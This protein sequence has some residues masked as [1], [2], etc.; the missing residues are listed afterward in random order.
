MSRSGNPAVRRAEEEA[1]RAAELARSE[2]SWDA[3]PFAGFPEE[4]IDHEAMEHAKADAEPIIGELVAAGGAVA[5]LEDELCRRLGRLLSAQDALRATSGTSDRAL[6]FDQ[7]AYSPELLLDV[8]S[9]NIALEA[10]RA[11][12]GI[13]DPDEQQRRWR[14]LVA[15]ARIVPHPD[16]RI[17]IGAVED[18]R[19]AVVQFPDASMVTTPTGPAMWCRDVY[20]TRFGI[21]APFSAPEGPDR[22]YLWDIDTCNGEAHTVGAGYFPTSTQ[23][24][25][26][27][28]EAVGPNAAAQA[29]LS[30]VSDAGLAD[31]ILPVAGE[32]RLGGESESQYAEFHRSRRLAQEL[33]A[34]ELRSDLPSTEPT[35]PGHEA[36]D[37]SW[38]AEFADWRAKHRPGQKAV[39]AGFPQDGEPFTDD[40]AYRELA[41]I[42]L[43]D[44]LP[45]LAHACSPHRITLAAR[46]IG[47]LYDPDTADVL[48]HLLPDLATWLTE[49][50][51]LPPEAA[52]RVLAC[53]EHVTRSGADLAEYAPD[54]PAR[55]REWAAQPAATTYPSQHSPV[56]DCPRQA[57]SA[58]KHT[59]SPGWHDRLHASN[60]RDHTSACRAG[61][62]GPLLPAPLRVGPRAGR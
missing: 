58:K 24:F 38:I 20:G 15:V 11:I 43:S 10:F 41:F 51:A 50:T 6:V 49:R 56:W 7:D 23:A 17:P 25:T 33:R 28:Q 61:G 3:D 5:W 45:H 32:R 22:W 55:I 31:R 57:S 35:R 59:R 27:W 44:E 54:L 12:A 60:R 48:R 21:T 13:D 34:A 47:D 37:D 29:R 39:P 42:W 30:P 4:E 46:S 52:D 53:A 62:A 18:L 2:R 9:E 14:L 1:A 36:A 26:A 19:E 8:F 40:E 16:S